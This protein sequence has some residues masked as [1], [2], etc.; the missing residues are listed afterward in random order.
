MVVR[1]FQNPKF[2]TRV[3]A[4]H[5]VRHVAKQWRMA[6]SLANLTPAR[7]DRGLGVPL[8]V[9]RPASSRS[10]EFSDGSVRDV[11]GSEVEFNSGRSNAAGFRTFVANRLGERTLIRSRN[12]T[13]IVA[14]GGPHQRLSRILVATATGSARRQVLQPPLRADLGTA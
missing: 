14:G 7:I 5:N 11:S 2:T 3:Y 12:G 4:K 9:Q 1:R 13:G 10:R 6:G 8:K